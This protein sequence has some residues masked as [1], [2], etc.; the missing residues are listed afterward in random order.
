MKS[1]IEKLCELC[2]NDH[3]ATFRDHEGRP[4]C[5]THANALEDGSWD[6]TE[7]R[8][9]PLAYADDDEEAEYVFVYGTLV[10]GSGYRAELEGWRK[11]TSGSYPTLLPNPDGVVTGEVHKVSPARL[12]QLDTYEGVPH[13]YK[14]LEAPMGVYV[15]VGDPARL[16]SESR[17]V[18]EQEHLQACMEDATL[19]LAADFDPRHLVTEGPAGTG[20]TSD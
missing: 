18:F 16:G 17:L 15:Y 3:T 4:V 7:H 13:L 6:G 1:Q 20:S 12:D 9:E 11:D 5:G 19:T 2:W 8:V 14:R 10:D